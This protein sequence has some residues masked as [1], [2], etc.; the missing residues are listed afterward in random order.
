MIIREITLNDY[1]EVATMYHR[2]IT[3]VFSE[4]RKISLIYFCYKMVI[5]WINDKK[6]IVV[7]EKNGVICGFSLCFVDDFNGLTEPIYNCDI[8]YVKPEYRKTRAAYL[9]YHNAYNIA[10]ELGLNIH[11]QGRIENGVKDMMIKHFNLKEKFTVLE[12]VNNG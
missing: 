7:A 11:S 12:G 6:H 5:D 8:A 10:K 1:E 9:L 4:D 2:F 3:E